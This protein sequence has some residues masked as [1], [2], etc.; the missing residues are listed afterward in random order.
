MHRGLR[1]VIAAMSL[2][3][4]LV[5]IQVA[6]PGTAHARCNG[7]TEAQVNLV[8]LNQTVASENPIAG[9][10]NDNNYYQGGYR[11]HRDDWRASVWIERNGWIGFFGPYGTALQAYDFHDN[12]TAVPGSVAMHLCLDDGTTWYCGVNANINVGGGVNH[13]SFVTNHGF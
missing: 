6:V 5:L 8:I 11:S 9:T 2:I 4:S 3:G 13:S 7:A 10:C 1:A 12:S